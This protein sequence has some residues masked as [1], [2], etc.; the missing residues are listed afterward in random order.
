MK[1]VN[2]LPREA[3]RSFGTFRGLGGGTTALLGALGLACV[4]A[5]ALVVTTNVVRTKKEDLNEVHRQQAA[6]AQQV[7]ALKPYAD[8]EATRAA[9]LERVRTL[10][11]TRYDWPTTLSRIARA[12]PSNTTLTDLNG[13]APASAGAAPTISLS[14]CTPSHNGVAKFIDRL[15]AVQGVS[16]VSL[17]SSKVATNAGGGTDSCGI[18]QFQLSIDLEAPKGA[19]AATPAATPTPTPAGG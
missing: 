1:A 14:G 19:T 6:A 13:S 2:L 10:A 16:G 15:R 8:L 5:F 17:Q 11:G 7:A 18:E 4:M 3:Q 9:L 12:V